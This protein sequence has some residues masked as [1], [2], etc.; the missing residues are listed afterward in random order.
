M[1]VNAGKL[2][3]WTIAVGILVLGLKWLA[4][5]LT[6]SVALYSDA[7]ESVVNVAAAI[8]AFIAIRISALPPDDNHPYGHSKAEYLS[9]V[10]EGAL[11]VFAALLI[12]H[13]AYQ[14]IFA[15]R[16]LDAP[17]IGLAVNGVATALNAI[18]A[19]VLIRGGAKARSPALAADGRHL[20]ADVVSS[21]GVVVGLVLAQVSG[22][23]WL[24][25]V[26]AIAVACNV[27]W[28]GWVLMRASIG[29]LMDE[30]PD[31]AV[32][33]QVEALIT[34]NGSGALQAHDIRMRQTGNRMFIEFHL[35]VPGEMTVEDAHT[36]CDRI[37]TAL[38]RSLGPVT[39]SIHVEP[40][41]KSKTDDIVE[42]D[43]Q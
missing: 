24:D 13:E 17:M 12:L 31:Q 37:E 39:V 1:T 7:L 25:P 35:I 33:D 10:S 27:L 11:I 23:T 14:S 20:M 41:H 43:V 2:A 18:W 28:S 38:R 40:D 16:Q 26:I 36:I 29:G 9:A 22:W 5:D 8:F 42:L 4:F 32:R 6:G 15:P 30:A 34:Q 19:V 21:V 3:L